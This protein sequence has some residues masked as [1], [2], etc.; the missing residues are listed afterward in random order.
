MNLQLFQVLFSLL[1]IFDSLVVPYTSRLYNIIM[2]FGVSF[3]CDFAITIRTFEVETE[4]LNAEIELLVT[5]FHS[6]IKF[7]TNVQIVGTSIA[8]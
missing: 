3:K 5:N 8:A 6:H 7:G 2:V 4:N 1:C